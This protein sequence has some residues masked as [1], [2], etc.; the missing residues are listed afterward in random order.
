MLAVAVLAATMAASPA[1]GA[2]TVKKAVWGPIER[3]GVSQIA[4]YRELGVG[5]YQTSLFWS[6][7]APKRPRNPRDPR[8]PAYRW[9]AGLAEAIAAAQ[10]GG[11]RVSIL[12]MQSP[13]W[14][15]GGHAD[16]TYAPKRASDFGDFAAAA[17][18]KYPGVHL[19]MIWGEP[20]R[21]PN[22]KPFV[23]AR[24][25]QTRLSRAQAAAPQRYAGILDAAY[26]ALKKVSRRNAVIG[27]ST[28]TTG[29]IST[30]AWIKY[31]RL[32]NGKR[33]RMDLYAHNP[34]SFRTP[35]F[36]NPASCCG[37][38]DFS[39]L[40][41][42]VKWIDRYLSP[43]RKLKLFLSEWKIPTDHSDY[44]FNFHVTREL[45][46][47]W[48]RRAFVYV[49]RWSR[50]YTLGWTGVYDDAP[51]PAGNELTGGLLDWQG[52]RKP[53]FYAFAAG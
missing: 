51:T 50:I 41:R 43:K 53:G 5:I 37:S 23:K 11:M 38:V 47:D 21:Q 25:G 45:Q 52:N 26:A 3:D 48:I 1:Y 42:L 12:L 19:W 44:E 31:M 15:N 32:P 34:F 20:S 33:P 13:P 27:G 40:P 24:P 4:L 49:R 17:A 2:Q 30:Y 16:G 18:R 28:Y 9:P 8:D 22:F 35:D 29:D 46:A 6:S 7:T 36:S 39:D 14:A 10:R